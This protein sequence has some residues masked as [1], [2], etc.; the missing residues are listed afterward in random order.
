MS[1]QIWT[2]ILAA[3]AGR[4]LASLTGGVPKQFW[5][6]A[7]GRSLL[8]QTVERFT[9]LAPSSRTVVI[10]DAGHMHHVAETDITGSLP[11]FVIQPEDRGTAAGVL[12]ALTPVLQSVPNAIVAITPSDHGVMD[13]TRFRRGVLQAAR[14]VVARDAIVLFGVQPAVAQ[15]D[16]GWISLGSATSSRGFRSVESFVEKPSS[17]VAERL[18]DAGAVWNTMVMVAR[19]AAI[20]SLYTRLLPNLAAVFAAAAQVPESK[21]AGFFAAEYP[22]L[23]KYDFSRDLLAHARNLSA[24]VL[25]ESVGW[26][27]LGTPERLI[28]WHQRREASRSAASAA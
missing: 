27:D 2:V 13:D 10:V 4:R 16:Y 23:P 5:R 14:Q 21:R 7:D 9:P 11:V 25:P 18:L 22:T 1:N 3:G 17:A 26:S 19:A 6:G 8:R 28:A 24:Y 15:R 12:L 20:R